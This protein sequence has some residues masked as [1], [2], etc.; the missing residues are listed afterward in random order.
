MKKKCI[1]ASLI[2]FILILFSCKKNDYK[3]QEPSLIQCNKAL[4]GWDILSVENISGQIQHDLFFPSNEI[5]FSVG[6]SETIMKTIDRGLNWE[7]QE[8]YYSQEEGIN[9]D[10]LTRAR[11]NLS[12]IHI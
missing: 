1:F 12:L 5:G 4:N 11:L 8:W 9:P 10:A 2:C 7:I 3:L 6:N